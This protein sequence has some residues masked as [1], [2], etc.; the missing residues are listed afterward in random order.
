MIIN[1]IATEE[2][3]IINLVL[4]FK[5]LNILVFTLIKIMLHYNVIIL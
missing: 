4:I 1:S 3:P 2:N 5:F